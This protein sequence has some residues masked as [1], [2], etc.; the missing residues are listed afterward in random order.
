MSGDTVRDIAPLPPLD[1]AKPRAT[2]VRPHPATRKPTRRTAER[3]YRPVNLS[4]DSTS[5]EALEDLGRRIRTPTGRRQPPS[6]IVRAFATALSEVHI[7]LPQEAD[8]DQLKE[9]FKR[10]LSR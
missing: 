4:L 10:L 2:A 7:R 9:T 3:S 6:V 8:E 5:Q 1:A